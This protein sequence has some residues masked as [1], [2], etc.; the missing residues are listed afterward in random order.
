MVTDAMPRLFIYLSK[1]LLVETYHQLEASRPGWKLDPKLRFTGVEITLGRRE[2]SIENLVWLAQKVT[3]AVS[4]QTGT[5]AYP[6][7]Y[8]RGRMPLTC[9][10]V[11]EKAAWMH[12][13]FDIEEG[14]AFVAL[15][16]SVY[17][18]RGYSPGDQ[19]DFKGWYPSDLMGMR[20]TM[21]SLTANHSKSW[22]LRTKGN[23]N[24]REGAISI[25]NA[26]AI[27]RWVPPECVIYQENLEV[28][29]EVF[30]H[31]SHTLNGIRSALLGAP[32]WVATPL[33]QANH[34]RS[35]GARGLPNSL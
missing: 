1:R 2:P 7:A 28:L 25:E 13:A 20:E 32:L 10:A 19:A 34:F 17:N 5:V 22:V 26:L 18:Y 6:G 4:D 27:S 11:P 23:A 9:A 30:V 14:P 21:E 3:E 15:C 12:S 8:V 35:L 33:P 29:F 16:G 31:E 24:V